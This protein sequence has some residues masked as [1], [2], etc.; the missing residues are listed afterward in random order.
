MYCRVVGSALQNKM[1]SSANIKCVKLRPLHWGW[2]LKFLAWLIC[3]MDLEKYSI[4]STK[5]KEERGSPCLKPWP[6]SNE[7]QSW[8]FIWTENVTEETHFIIHDA[9]MGRNFRP[10]RRSC[11]KP[12]C[13]ESNA[14]CRSILSIQRG[15][16]CCL[17]YPSAKSWQMRMLYR[18]SRPL[19]NAPWLWWMR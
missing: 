7:P 1:R 11:K 16:I 18:I 17:W 8:P 13:I 12:Q 19:T 14:F 3:C 2:Y 6:P 9:K 4:V 5:S 10:T 15:E